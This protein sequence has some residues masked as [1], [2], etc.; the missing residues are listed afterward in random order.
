VDNI[1]N[2][3]VKGLIAITLTVLI[4]LGLGAPGT[5]MASALP[6][7]SISGTTPEEGA[8]AVV[9]PGI[10]YLETKWTAWVNDGYEWLNGGRPFEWTSRCTGFVVNPNGYIATTGHCVDAGQ[11]GAKRTARETMYE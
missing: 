7:T 9:Q 4:G 2:G 6:E 8:A 3:L 1:W 10:V 11:E 5:A